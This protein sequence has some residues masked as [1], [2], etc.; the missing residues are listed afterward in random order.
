MPDERSRPT[1]GGGSVGLGGHYPQGCADLLCLL[2]LGGIA[3]A[4]PKP[5][6]GLRAMV[7]ELRRLAPV[8]VSIVALPDRRGDR[9]RYVAH[10]GLPDRPAHQP[11]DGELTAFAAQA[12]G[13]RQ[14]VQ[15][16]T[17]DADLGGSGGGYVT[18]P[19]LGADHALGVLG[20]NLRDGLPL[21]SW[22]EHVL[23]AAADLMALVLLG[24][25]PVPAGSRDAL[26]LTRR[27]ADVLHELVE[28]GASNEQIAA[29]LGLSARTVKV[30]LRAVY[31]Q[32]GVRRR[33]EAI[34]LVLTRHA[35]W[36]A[37]ERERRQGGGGA[38]P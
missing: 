1:R 20:V 30:H 3:L 34:Q 7:D 26:R 12:M 17:A 31:R 27:Q 36:L 29:S 32:L 10:A 23:W 25:R 38:F 9:L 37:R 4:G 8:N 15:L 2:R 28:R 21:D 24:D 13:T 33:G 16:A 6:T 22:F 14:I 19:I 5:K 11:F 18:V 35:G